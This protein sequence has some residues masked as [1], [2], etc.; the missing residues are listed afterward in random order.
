MDNINLDQL[1]EHLRI[2]Y[3]NAVKMYLLHCKRYSRSSLKKIS[4]PKNDCNL[5][6]EKLAKKMQKKFNFMQRFGVFLHLYSIRIFKTFCIMDTIF[7][8][9]TAIALILSVFLQFECPELLL[10]G[11]FATPYL[12]AATSPKRFKLKRLLY[13]IRAVYL[14]PRGI[15]T[16]FLAKLVSCRIAYQRGIRVAARATAERMPAK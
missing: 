15:A 8:V 5:E 16:Q 2:S 12:L 1:A 10:F 13:F 14:P 6:N 9:F 11:I 4:L 3:G 7:L